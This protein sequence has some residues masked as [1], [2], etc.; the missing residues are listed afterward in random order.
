MMSEVKF[1][2]LHK[3]NER[4]RARLEQAA[5]R[6][7]NSGWYVLGLENRDFEA[8]FA[9]YCGCAHALGAANGLD[10]LK[11]IIQAYGFG[12]GDEI[13]VPANTYIAS[14]LAVTQNGAAP[15]LVEPDPATCNIDPTQIEEK[16]TVRTRAILPVHL[17]GRLAPMDEINTVARK[18]G[19]KVIEDAAQAHGA[20]SGGRR[21]GTLGDAAGFSFYPG[22][23]LG[24]LGDG[25]AM[26][27]ND[28]RLAEKLEALRNYGSLRKYEHLYQGTNSRLDELQAA[29]LSVKLETLDQDNAR[30]REVAAAYLRGLDNP[31]VAKPANGP[32]EAN[33]WHLFVVRCP[34]RDD[35]QKYL[36]D[37]GVQTLIHYPTPPHHQKAYT[38]WSAQ[39]LPITEKIHREALSLPMSPVLTGE[40]I[41]RVIEAVNAFK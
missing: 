19:L 6:V 30:R 10:A 15:V 24:A 40:E 8:A 2:D 11:L 17:Y 28:P 13:I 38:E 37:Q 32:A 3:V 36:A 14:I 34:R 35:L 39:S 33:V 20:A 21:A 22:K 16:I 4:F 9:A 29:F 1:L 26:T 12:P 41:S 27:T 31:L 23:N 7:F 5:A 18:Y 25:G